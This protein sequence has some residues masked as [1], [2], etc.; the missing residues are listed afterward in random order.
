MALDLVQIRWQLIRA[1]ESNQ[2]IEQENIQLRKEV[3]SLRKDLEK[4]RQPTETVGFDPK[5]MLRITNAVASHGLRSRAD[6]QKLRA[7]ATT[8]LADLAK[9]LAHIKSLNSNC[10]QMIVAQDNEAAAAAKERRK[11]AQQVTALQ[12]ELRDSQT[13][14]TAELAVKDEYISNLKAKVKDLSSAKALLEAEA[15]ELRKAAEAGGSEARALAQR[16]ADS[17][18]EVSKLSAELLAAQNSSAMMLAESVESAR[19]AAEGFQKII[20]DLS[21]DNTA[22]RTAVAALEEQISRLSGALVGNKS[23]FAKYVEVKTENLALQSKLDTIAKVLPA[24]YTAA[25]NVLASANDGRISPRFPPLDGIPQSA[26]S[27][28]SGGQPVGIPQQQQRPL[29]RG[30]GQP[31]AG[32][33]ARA[34]PD[35]PIGNSRMVI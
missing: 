19:R 17:R 18:T 14:L 15:V 3:A 32:A 7:A 23:H 12:A 9:A 16:L 21:A 10:V 35:V 26:R 13:N 20:A 30:Q 34:R 24:K 22:L 33:A 4:A 28:T 5:M 8:D 27:S 25:A 6:L 2:S 11:L 31:G 1:A 29:P